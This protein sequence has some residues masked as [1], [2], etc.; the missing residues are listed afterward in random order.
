[1]ILPIMKMLKKK[2]H[3]D[4]ALAQDLMTIELYNSIPEAVIHGGTALW[5]CYR[6]NRFSEDIDAYL[7]KR[8]RSQLKTFLNNLKSKGFVVNKFREK[9]NSV[10]SVISYM[11]TVVRFEAVF[12]NVKSIVEPYEMSDGT[13]INVRTLKPN[14]LIIE[15]I[16]AYKKRKKIK[17]LYDIFFLLK[18]AEIGKIRKNLL[19]FIK[20]FEEPKDKADLKA[21][22][23][24]GA[25]PEI[26]DMLEEIKKWAGQST[27]KK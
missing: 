5:R 19:N 20:E 4:T 27:S 23:I 21:L 22:I 26:K 13:F 11:G 6:G 2:I 24:S 18:H 1:M 16:S 7:P 25:I 17:D 14:T 8:S 9:E 15:K 12:E 10:F 3:K